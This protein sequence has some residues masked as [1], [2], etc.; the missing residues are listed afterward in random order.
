VPRRYPYQ[1]DREDAGVEQAGVPPIPWTETKVVGK[2]IPR[3]DAYE[4]VSGTAVFPSDVTLPDTLYA[5]VLRCPHAHANVKRVDASAA[6]RMPGVRAIITGSTPGVA[7]PWY[8]GPD[9][10]PLS[11]LF[12][13]HCRFEGEEVGAVAAET[14]YEAWDAVR[15]IE[16]EYEV[17]AFV[18]TPEDALKPGAPPVHGGGNQVGKPQIFERGNIQ[19]GFSQANVVLEQTYRTACELHT[20]TE[21]HGSVAKWDGTRL[22]VWDSTQ[23][24][25]WI[26]AGV[27]QALSLPLSSVRVIGHYVGGGFGSKIDTSKHTIIAAILSKM[28]A[29]PVKLFLTREETLL[30]VGNRPANTMTVKAGVRKDG[31]LT[32]LQLTC[33]GTGGAYLGDGV[34]G[35]DWQFRDL[36]LCPNVRTESTDTF[37]NAGPARPMRAPG[38]PQGSWA[39]E[40]MMDDLAQQIGMDPVDLRLRNIPAASQGTE[41][42]PPYSST[43]LREC[44]VEGARAFGWRE[45]RARTHAAGPIRRGVGVAAG[46]WQGGGAWP[47]ATIV[48]KLFA[49]GSVNLNMGAAD[50]GTGTKTV[51]AMVVSEELGIPLDRIRIEHADTATTQF[52]NPSGGSKTV[53]TE[54]PAVREAA[55]AVKRELLQLAAEQLKLP[56]SDLSLVGGE[57]VPRAEPAKR[58]TIAAVAGLRRRGVLVGVGTRDPD[59]EGKVICPFAAQFVE[60]E[61]NTLTGETSVVR[62]VAAHD[63]GR[64]MNLLSYANQ[65]FGGVTMGIGLALTEA[66]ILDRS[67]T[68]KM[69]NV[70]WHDYKVPTAMDVP[71]DLACVPVDLHDT[72]CNS[73]GAKGLGEPATIPTAAAVGNAVFHA[74]GSRATDAPMTPARV[75]ESLLRKPLP[76]AARR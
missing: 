73:A 29:R 43:G 49:D 38:H 47:P 54:A 17:L 13:S 64:V 28:T 31:T 8:P 24:V 60:V 63:S 21:P 5:A 35:V 4:R 33:V 14:P 19:A 15:A 11:R 51:M 52:T 68:G 70:N 18:A 55:L 53:P 48:V 6:G 72:Q 45:A 65:V 25:F 61:V 40:Q 69:V 44:L 12:D 74:T 22:T 58:L 16:V 56:V 30:A 50:L 67:R 57:I 27:A 10:K 66:R 32:A 59:T 34:G 23:G 76:A 3:I 9:G 75:L 7:L 26:Q 36:Y 41:G 39:L 42:Q 62:V 71:A 37:V 20:T 46:L 2:S 1:P